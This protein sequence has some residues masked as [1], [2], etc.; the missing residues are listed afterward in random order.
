MIMQYWRRFQ[1]P[2]SEAIKW[3]QKNLTGMINLIKV[4]CS[5]TLLSQHCWILESLSHFHI[6]LFC[7]IPDCRQMEESTVTSPIGFWSL[8][9]RWVFQLFLPSW[10]NWSSWGQFYTAD[11]LPF[12][13]TEWP[14]FL[15]QTIFIQRDP[16]RK[17]ELNRKAFTEV[18]TES[19]SP[20]D[21]F[22]TLTLGLVASAPRSYWKWQNS[23]GIELE[24]SNV[25][26]SSFLSQLPAQ[27]YISLT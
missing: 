14:R 9:L 24:R 13:Y 26:P 10:W 7:T 3:P 19:C 20:F 18:K 16:K 23:A 4:L 25:A 2:G 6:S 15:K 27:C 21:I 11:N 12:W 22:D 8:A 1:T 5:M 17:T